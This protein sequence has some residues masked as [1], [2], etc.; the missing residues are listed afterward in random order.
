MF[1]C[2]EI[3]REGI[4]YNMEEE[5]NEENLV[6]CVCHPQCSALGDKLLPSRTLWSVGKAATPLHNLSVMWLVINLV[7]NAQERRLDSR[8]SLKK[9]R[10][11][12]ELL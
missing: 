1:L 12:R 2:R 8:T 9:G 11:L 7:I 5:S 10:R 6:Y 4:V 3:R